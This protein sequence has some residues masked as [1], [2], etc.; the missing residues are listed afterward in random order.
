[1]KYGVPQGAVLSPT[2]YNIYT[3][4][5]TKHAGKCNIGLFADDTCIY[6]SSKY[7]E[8]ITNNLNKSFG[9]LHQYFVK[10]K[11]NINA[12]KTKAIYFTKR[13]TKE[14][15]TTPLILHHQSIP[16]ANKI[17][18]L[19][20]VLD[21]RLTLNEHL[22]EMALKTNKIVRILYS[23]LNKKSELN[24]TNKLLIYK[25]IIRPAMC[26][27]S[28]I[29]NTAAKTNITQLQ[30]IQNKI[31]KMCLKLPWFTSTNYIHEITNIEKIIDFNNKNYEKFLDK[32]PNNCR[33]QT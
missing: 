26:Y 12:E 23:L 29:I 22:K 27:A 20:V 4:D 32:I 9:K 17:K 10:W 15:P 2:L 33:Y 13:R 25:Q 16:W 11:I 28:P 14:I 30:T 31:L 1:M 19:G 18:Y 8:S 7:L 6:Y 21:K 5:I 24:E 3:F